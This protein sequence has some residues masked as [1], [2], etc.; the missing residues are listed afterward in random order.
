M[1]VDFKKITAKAKSF[2]LEKDGVVFSG[3]F[4]KDRDLVDIDG[5]LKNEIEVICDRCSKEFMIKLDE[6]IHLKACEGIFK[7]NLEDTDVVEFYD[8]YVDFDEILNSE[9]ESIK[10]DYH[11]CDECKKEDEFEKEF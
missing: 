7:G 5:K 9:I 10:L 3:V 6:K 1:K 8:G 4:K 2:I 11:L